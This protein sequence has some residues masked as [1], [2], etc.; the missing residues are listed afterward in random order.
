MQGLT[1]LETLKLKSLPDTS[2]KSIWKSLLLSNLTTLEVNECKRITHVFTYSMIASLV[3]LKVLKIWLCEEL[4]QIIAKDDDERDQ[5]LSVS[6][7]QSL[8]FPSL[9]KI[10]VRE[11]R[12][13]KNLFPIA[14]A[15]G[16]LKLKI[17]REL[18]LEQ[19]PSI[20][21]FIL[22]C[23]DFL[24]P[25]LKK[26]KV[27]ECPNLTTNFD[28]TPNG[29]MSARYKISQVAEDSSDDCSVPTNSYRI[30]TRDDGW[31]E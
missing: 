13:L 11:C 25:R 5:I 9:C 29:S 31:E 19:L 21:S 4:E 30:W 2:M 17:L 10:E 8:C 16:L 20:S 27:Y 15:S 6:R 18:S 1:R 26:L 23:Y 28:T 24:F 22:G 3:H 12:K 7:L 14:M